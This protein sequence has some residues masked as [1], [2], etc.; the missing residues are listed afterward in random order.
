M[1]A[2]KKC[3]VLDFR[4]VSMQVVSIDCSPTDAYRAVSCGTDRCIKVRH[5]FGYTTACLCMHL[6]LQLKSATLTILIPVPKG[7]KM[8]SLALAASSGRILRHWRLQ[9]WDLSRGFQVNTFLQP[10]SVNGR[11]IPPLSRASQDSCLDGADLL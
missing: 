3:R 9:V 4:V 10:S 2:S 8:I 11:C 6:E 7:L 1:G 5:I